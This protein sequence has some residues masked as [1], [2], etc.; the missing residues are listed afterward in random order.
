[1]IGRMSFV[2]VILC[3]YYFVGIPFVIFRLVAFF[4][5]KAGDVLQ[6]VTDP[7]AKRKPEKFGPA[8]T[9][10]F[11]DMCVAVNGGVCLGVGCECWAGL[12]ESLSE[13]F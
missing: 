11:A 2:G 1:M 3:F 5:H 8:L 6:A 13:L 9:R 12:F 10:L 4:S 7:E